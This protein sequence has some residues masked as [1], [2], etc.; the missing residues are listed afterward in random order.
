LNTEIQAFHLP[1]PNVDDYQGK[2]ETEPMPHFIQNL[3]EAEYVVA[4]YQ[5]IRL[6]G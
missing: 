5:Y 1:N 2:G 3:G 6:Q 4:V